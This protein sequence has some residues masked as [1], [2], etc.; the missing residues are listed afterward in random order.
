MAYLEYL[1][2]FSKGRTGDY[3]NRAFSTYQGEEEAMKVRAVLANSAP[4]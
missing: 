2:L 4:Q 1:E 3:R